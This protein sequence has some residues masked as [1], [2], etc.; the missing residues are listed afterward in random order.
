MSQLS[1][2]NSFTEPALTKFY[3]SYFTVGVISSS[4]EASSCYPIEKTIETSSENLIPVSPAITF[5]QINSFS[6]YYTVINAP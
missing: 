4:F 3:T 1:V 2:G 6:G 5:T